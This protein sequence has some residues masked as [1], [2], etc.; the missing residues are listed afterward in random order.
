MG[1][2]QS[3]GVNFALEKPMYTA[4]DTVKGYVELDVKADDVELPEFTVE[5]RGVAFSA[6]SYSKSSGAGRSQKSVTKT[7]RTRRTIVKVQSKVDCLDKGRLAKGSKLQIPFALLIPKDAPSAMPLITSGHYTKPHQAQIHY[8]IGIY[9]SKP[10]AL[11]G[12]STS[13][14]AKTLVDIVAL[15]PTLTD[16]ARQLGQ[17]SV[18]RCGCIPAGSINFAVLSSL[19]AFKAG[20]APTVTYEVDNQTSQEI[21]HISVYVER[22]VTWIA[23]TSDGGHSRRAGITYKLHAKKEAGLGPGCAFGMGGKEAARTVTLSIPKSAFFSTNTDTVKVRYALVV[24]AKTASRFV[25][26]PT[27]RLPLTA[28]GLAGGNSASKGA[29]GDEGEEPVLCKSAVVDYVPFGSSGSLP[30]KLRELEE[31]RSAGLVTEAE[32]AASKQQLLTTPIGVGTS[33]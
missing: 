30:R 12:K 19:T 9:A 5:L 21:E 32:F 13:A 26:D 6:V 10:V 33:F 3:I 4:G 18:T 16:P 14:L 1:S 27:L 8:T 24:K 17:I 23:Y 2:S 25:K 29:V 28:Y 20:D 22:T 7:A 31:A 15:P 11:W